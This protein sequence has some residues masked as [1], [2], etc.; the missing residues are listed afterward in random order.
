MAVHLADAISS[1][2]PRQSGGPERERHDT[3]NPPADASC[4]L[5]VAPSCRPNL[6][7]PQRAVG[8]NLHRQSHMPLHMDLPTSVRAAR[9][10]GDRSRRRC[11]Q[12]ARS[13]PHCP[14]ARLGLGAN[15]GIRVALARS[16]SD[17]G[18]RDPKVQGGQRNLA[19]RSR[20]SPLSRQPSQAVAKRMAVTEV[21]HQMHAVAQAPMGAA[22]RH[23]TSHRKVRGH[24]RTPR[25]GLR[26]ACNH[27]RHSWHPSDHM[28]RD[29][30]PPYI[31]QCPQSP[32]KAGHPRCRA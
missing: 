27:R 29:C 7:E 8:R 17:R 25:Q 12:C 14:A 5:T 21:Y 13:P 28:H 31:P 20:R 10:A 1:H 9:P 32:S 22:T 6:D 18:P 19:S 16:P 3:T 4:S 11:C 15:R 23:G 24:S 26:T 2:Q 30:K